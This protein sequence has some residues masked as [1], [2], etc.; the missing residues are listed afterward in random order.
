MNHED[1]V[2]LI[3]AGIPALGGIWADLG[4]G[5]GAFTLALAEVLGPTGLIYSVD[6]DKDAL[7]EQQRA[8]QT[9]FPLYQVRYINTDFT[10]IMDL[11][12]L[13]GILMTNSLH[14]VQDDRKAVVLQSIKNLLKAGGRFLIVEY[15]VDRGNLWV[16]YPQSYA[17]WEKLAYQA[18]FSQTRLLA[19]HPSRFL[20]ELYSAV[21]W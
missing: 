16:P 5:T 10:R 15:N 2:N 1:H 13:D 8:M 17:A 6:R 14:F 7:K 9:R 3:R 21:S 4:S 19:V 18:G 11:P 20:K 12:K